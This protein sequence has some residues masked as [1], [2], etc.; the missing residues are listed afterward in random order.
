M[1]DG[2]NVK[3]CVL[4]KRSAILFYFIW[5]MYKLPEHRIL[6]NCLKRTPQYSSV[7]ANYFEKKKGG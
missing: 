2:R 7:L 4:R 5:N 6:Y 1:G 3:D